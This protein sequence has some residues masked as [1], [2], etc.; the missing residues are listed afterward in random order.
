MSKENPTPAET[1]R[2]T[3]RRSWSKGRKKAKSKSL[4]DFDADAK[5]K[6]SKKGY[7]K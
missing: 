4:R 1:L 3:I 2:A 7:K 5:E 6:V